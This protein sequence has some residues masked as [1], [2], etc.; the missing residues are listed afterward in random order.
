MPQERKFEHITTDSHLVEFCEKAAGSEFIGFDTEFVSENRYRPELCLIQVAADEQLAII[1]TLA[2]KD[3]S[4]FW[5]LLVEGSHVT[6]AHAAREEQLFCFRASDRTPANLFDVQLAAGFTGLEYPASY[7]NLISRLLGITIDK[8]ETRTDWKRRPLSQSQIE[9]ALVDV[10][11]LRPLYDK[12]TQ[13]LKSMERMEWLELETQQRTDAL[14][15]SEVEPQWHRMPGIS[16]LSRGPLAIV[17]QLWIWRDKEAKK[18]N[19]SP[20]RILPDDLLVEVA[21]RGS[22]ETRKLK[23]IRGLEN[24]IAGGTLGAIADTIG[25]ALDL[26][27]SEWPQRLPRGKSMNLGSLGQF[28]TTA[29]G[30]VCRSN[31]IAPSIVGTAQD[32]RNLAA[33]KLGMVKLKEPPAMANGW[34]RELVGQ[35][36]EQILSGRIAIRVD[37]PR[38]DNPLVLEEVQDFE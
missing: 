6:I 3:V 18:R 24:R 25:D 30:V 38:S 34:R 22:R 33:E 9:Y 19:R 2:V 1:D 35:L 11:H 4:P 13:K 10:I 17:R 31:Q 21:K 14:V 29:L 36:I 37:D 7:G 32:V 27:K 23:A 26:P 5:N 28:L 16:S 12:L 15:R 8:G 20:R